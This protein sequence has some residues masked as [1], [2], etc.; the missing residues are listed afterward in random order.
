MKEKIKKIIKK[1]DLCRRFVDEGIALALLEHKLSP[2]QENFWLKHIEKCES[3]M[4]VIADV[5]YAD[6]QMKSLSLAQSI[7]DITQTQEQEKKTYV[8]QTG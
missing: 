5:L 6:S 2:E 1:E 7:G 8:L 4:A 3:C